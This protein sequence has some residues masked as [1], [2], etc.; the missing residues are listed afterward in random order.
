MEKRI[1]R[2]TTWL[3]LIVLAVFICM[4]GGAVSLFHDMFPKAE[5]IELPEEEH[6]ISVSLS[7][8]T[9]D[10]TAPMAEEDVETLFGYIGSAVPTRQQAMDDHPTERLYYGITVQTAERQYDYFIY[11][12]EDRVY[13]EIPYEGI[14]EAD[15]ELLSLVLCYFQES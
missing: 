4:V 12:K 1:K 3:L 15:S 11:E 13:L 9:S 8:S 5:P 7:C 6:V 10:L 14:Y 2:K